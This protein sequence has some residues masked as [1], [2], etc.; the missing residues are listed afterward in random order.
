[1]W[2]SGSRVRNSGSVGGILSDSTGQTADGPNENAGRGR[3]WVAAGCALP[4]GRPLRFAPSRVGRRVENC[5]ALSRFVA[6]DG[7]RDAASRLRRRLWR[8]PA[9]QLAE[10]LV[11]GR[12][13]V[14]FGVVGL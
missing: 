2:P 4:G 5:R 6:R 8:D 9:L 13:G 3:A 12:G 10:V 14:A 11:Q 1:M 7:P